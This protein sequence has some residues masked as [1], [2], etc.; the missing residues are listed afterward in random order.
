MKMLNDISLMM[1]DVLLEEDSIMNKLMLA[2][3]RVLPF[4]MQNPAQKWR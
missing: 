4:N 2:N 3:Q 1:T